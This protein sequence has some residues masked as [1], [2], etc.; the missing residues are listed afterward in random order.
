M[1]FLLSILTLLVL[2][3]IVLCYNFDCWTKYGNLYNKDSIKFMLPKFFYEKAFIETIT[4][5]CLIIC[6]MFLFLVT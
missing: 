1:S 4:I 5:I 3:F 2:T 6:G